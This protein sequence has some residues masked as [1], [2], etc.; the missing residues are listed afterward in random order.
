MASHKQFHDETKT[1]QEDSSFNAHP[2]EGAPSQSIEASEIGLRD[3]INDVSDMR[4]LGKKQ[5][6]RVKSPRTY[7]QM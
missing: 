1:E 2:E 4:R 3:T 6:F 7:I 5:E